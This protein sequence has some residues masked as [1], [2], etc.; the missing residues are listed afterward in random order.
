MES[1]GLPYDVIEVRVNELGEGS[2]ADVSFFYSVLQSCSQQMD[3]GHV[4]LEGKDSHVY[5]LCLDMGDGAFKIV[6]FLP[7]FPRFLRMMGAKD[8]S[9]IVS[10]LQTIPLEYVRYYY[11]YLVRSSQ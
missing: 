8:A 9:K 11:S 1:E 7:D 5:G 10:W 6:F 4:Y 3:K 2:R